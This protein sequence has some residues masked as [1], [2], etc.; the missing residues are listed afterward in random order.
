MDL[1][2]IDVL[3]RNY[4]FIKQEQYTI[5]E[6]VTKEYR[7]FFDFWFRVDQHKR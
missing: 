4:K 3:K 7:D 5:Q 1:L 6:H 2:W